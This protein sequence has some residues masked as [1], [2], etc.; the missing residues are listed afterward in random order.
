M[1]S[2]A[3]KNLPRRIEFWLLWFI[4][5]I[6]ID[7]WLK[8]SYVFNPSDILSPNITH[9]KLVL[10]MVIAYII[11]K[12]WRIKH[13]SLKTYKTGQVQA[14]AIPWQNVLTIFT[15][16][17]I[18]LSATYLAANNIAPWQDVYTIY[19]IVLA[20]LGF[21]T[22]GFYYGKTR[23]YEQILYAIFSTQETSEQMFK[24][25]IEGAR[26]HEREKRVGETEENP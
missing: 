24:K 6:L 13:K 19:L 16:A 23:A 5:A 21:V 18:I 8:E 20:G 26:K 25:V 14:L 10:M 1:K 9:E 15:V 12:V 3:W 11:F 22:T 7:E 17:L 4:L 2:N